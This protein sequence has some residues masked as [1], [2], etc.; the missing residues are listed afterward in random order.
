MTTL[1]AKLAVGFLPFTA[2]KPKMEAANCKQRKTEAIIEY[3][4]AVKEERMIAHYRDSGVNI[5]AIIANWRNLAANSP[6]GS[7]FTAVIQ[8]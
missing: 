6:P 5:N 8:F 1:N 7:S 3:T 4:A 2:I